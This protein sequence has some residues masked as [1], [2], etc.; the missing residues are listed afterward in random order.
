MTES[1]VISWGEMTVEETRSLAERY[2]L[3]L[4]KEKMRCEDIERKSILDIGRM[5][6]TMGRIE[7]ERDRYMSEVHSLKTQIKNIK[8]IIDT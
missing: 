5:K 3:E 8:I 2:R 6:A 1:S 7:K 4:E